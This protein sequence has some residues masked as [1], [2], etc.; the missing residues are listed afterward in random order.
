MQDRYRHYKKR[1]WR[2]RNISVND[3]ENNNNLV[4]FAR[5]QAKV[6]EINEEAVLV[7]LA[8][9][10]YHYTWIKR[11]VLAILYLSQIIPSLGLN[12]TLSTSSVQRLKGSWGISPSKHLDNTRNTKSRLESSKKVIPDSRPRHLSSQQQ[13]A[14][15]SNVSKN[16]KV[17][18]TPSKQAIKT[19]FKGAQQKMKTGEFGKASQLL[20]QI[21]KM[22]PYDSHSYLALGRLESRRELASQISVFPNSIS[23]VSSEKTQ[24]RETLKPSTP[25][26]A[27]LLEEERP[28]DGLHKSVAR[29]TFD[30]GTSKCP[31]SV[32][33]WQAWAV[34]EQ[35]LGH[36]NRAKEL[37]ER[38][39]TIDPTNPY[40]CHAYGLMMW[41]RLARPDKARRLWQNSLTKH[42]TAALVC[43]LGELETIQGNL[44]KARE[45]Y[46][47]HLPRLRVKDCERE[48]VEVYLSAAWL[49]DRNQKKFFASSN[50]TASLTTPESILEEALKY[51]PENSRIQVALARLQA[52]TSNASDFKNLIV[53][54]SD[55][56]SQELSTESTATE[57]QDS[58]NQ[59]SST[60]ANFK[61][62]EACEQ[63]V[64]SSESL[65]E[66]NRIRN[67]LQK[68]KSQDN[69][70]RHA[71]SQASESNPPQYTSARASRAQDDDQLTSLRARKGSD[72]RLY[73]AW[74]KL[75][76]KGGRLR[77]AKRILLE[78]IKKFPR[79]HSVSC[80]I[81][82]LN[83][84]FLVVYSNANF[85]SRLFMLP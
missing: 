75:E 43:S 66:Q 45:I 24:D 85:F 62:S 39:L 69:Q 33:L 63:M 44:D 57:Q 21:L 53:P 35:S 32:H 74:A 79:D 42:S 61:L 29:N 19:M 40:V 71:N 3:E 5:Q 51:Y 56:Y 80:S 59:S 54:R 14:S 17:Y 38:A 37:Y 84:F 78:G 73:N 83:D 58:P 28:L 47:T 7:K 6:E 48:T 18:Y 49:E 26:W 9:R 16:N 34:H 64:I 25:S 11:V 22:D 10:S 46:A 70:V 55:T 20:K 52:R 27:T 76:V 8:P 60:L 68:A 36:L 81:P 50:I 82:Y 4:N 72:G 23:G 1:N 15:S 30:L 2:V 12:P 13:K 41:Q 65:R 67:L 77:N 31:D